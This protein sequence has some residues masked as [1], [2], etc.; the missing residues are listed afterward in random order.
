MPKCSLDK[1]KYSFHSFIHLSA[2][3]GTETTS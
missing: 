3:T 1:F 2:Q